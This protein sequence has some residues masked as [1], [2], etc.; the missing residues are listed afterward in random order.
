VHAWV[1]ELL[2]SEGLPPFFLYSTPPPTL[3]PEDETRTLADA[4]LQPAVLL[5]LGWG[6]SPGNRV[7]DAPATPSA[8]LTPAALDVANGGAGAGAGAGGGGGSSASA[9]D[10][11]PTA[12]PL[13]DAPAMDIDAA[14]AAL[15]SGGGRGPGAGANAGKSGAGAGAGAGAGKGGKPGWLKL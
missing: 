9:A 13:V 5:Y 8:Y 4:K 1:R 10:I 14:A 11:F 15:L 12:V 6:T 3:V 7:A 2:L